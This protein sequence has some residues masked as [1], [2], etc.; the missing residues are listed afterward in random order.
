[1]LTRCCSFSRVCD[2]DPSPGS[3]LHADE[4]DKV[5]MVRVLGDLV[6]AGAGSEKG[7]RD[8]ARFGTRVTEINCKFMQDFDNV[9]ARRRQD[10]EMGWVENA[11]RKERAMDRQH[12]RVGRRKTRGKRTQNT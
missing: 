10:Y 12:E 8:D 5:W 11:R 7:S 6:N 4:L 1:M 3:T 9:F 2:A